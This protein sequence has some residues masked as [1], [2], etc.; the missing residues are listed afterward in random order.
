MQLFVKAAI[1]PLYYKII[2]LKELWLMSPPH[3]PEI[4]VLP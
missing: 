4:Y 3:L 2:F 1:F